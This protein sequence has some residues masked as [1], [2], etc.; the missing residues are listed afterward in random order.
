MAHNLANKLKTVLNKIVHS[1]QSCYIKG[2]NINFNIRL[3]QD[4]IEYFEDNE[5]EDAII[6]LDFQKAFDMVS[7][8]FLQDVLIKLNFGNSFIKWV[9]VMYK[10]AESCVT[11]N[12]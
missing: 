6:F 8:K 7:H 9:Q 2:R 3:I 12:D 11:N 4:G 10:N 1:D 5:L